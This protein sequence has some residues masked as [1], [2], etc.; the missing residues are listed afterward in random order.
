MNFYDN[1]RNTEDLISDQIIISQAITT[2]LPEYT[3]QQ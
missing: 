1:K 2:G 3:V